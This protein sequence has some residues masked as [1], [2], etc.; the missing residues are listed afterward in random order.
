MYN[1]SKSFSNLDEL[2]RYLDEGKRTKL[3][4]YTESSRTNSS[5]FTGTESYEQAN[6]LLRDGDTE[7]AE[8]LKAA[9]GN[10]LKTAETGSRTRRYSHVCGGAVNVPAM[11]MSL[12]KSMIAQKKIIYKEGKVL[13]FVYNQTVESKIKESEISD[14][15]AKLVSAVMG[16]EKRG[17]R[18]NLFYC[19][20]AERTSAPAER[21][22]MF[23]RI[24]D[25]SQ[26]FDTKKL[27]YPL[28]NPSMLRRHFFRF[29]ETA[30]GL[31]NRSWLYTYGRVLRDGGAIDELAK[32]AG[33]TPRRVVSFYDIRYK[34]AP[35]I[36]QLLLN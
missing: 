24:K 30:P 19:I 1:F 12:P 8:R 32:G 29:V 36:M 11:L 28:V 2:R 27:A 31:N 34:S 23:V 9:T 10:G 7:R 14:V 16:L 15:S 20:C 33:L 21:V 4:E 25:S 13:S 3:F 6:T 17:Y 5:S 35:E 26:Y 22:G 18:V